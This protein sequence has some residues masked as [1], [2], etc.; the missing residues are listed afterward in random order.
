MLSGR[1]TAGSESEGGS[2]GST[3]VPARS[4]TSSAPAGTVTA[5]TGEVIRTA[6]VVGAAGRAGWGA[7]G[8]ATGVLAASALTGVMV[9]AGVGDAVAAVRGAAGLSTRLAGGVPTRSGTRTSATRTAPA[10]DRP[11]TI[12]P[13]R[14]RNGPAWRLFV[15][16]GRMVPR[17]R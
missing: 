3:A 5:S 1:S 7:T 9:I 15:V 16:T 12:A 13:R 2:Q 14:A 8:A 11:S 10:T 6:G 4:T 17:G